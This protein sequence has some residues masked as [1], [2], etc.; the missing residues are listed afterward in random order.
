MSTQHTYPSDLT[1]KQW[2]RI[3]PLLPPPKPGGRPRKVKMREV[4]NAIMYIVRS[5]CAWRMLPKS[6]PPWGTVYTYF[7]SFQLNGVWQKMHDSLREDVR[8]EAGRES[9]PS[10]G[11]IDSQSV[12]TTE[13][14]GF[15]DMTP[16]RRFSDGNVTSLSIRSG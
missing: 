11:I 13:K 7:R 4:A 9:T 10:A 8:R 6:F 3:E 16:A 5:G 15:A 14:G 1:D 2:E 12:K